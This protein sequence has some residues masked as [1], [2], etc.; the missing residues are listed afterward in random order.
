M[1]RIFFVCIL[2]LLFLMP[3]QMIESAAYTMKSRPLTPSLLN[4][5]RQG[6]YILYVRHGEAAVGEDQ[7]I[8]QL[9]DCSSQRNLTEEGRRQAVNFGESLRDLR[10]PVETPVEASPLCRTRESAELAFGEGNVQT[11]PF[12]IRIYSLGGDLSPAGQ[13]A[14]LVALSSVLERIPSVGT[15]KVIIAHSFPPGV[16]LG[17][18]PNLGTIVVKPRGQGNGYEIVSKITLEEW[19]N[20]R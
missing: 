4:S 2:A 12:W 10:I 6:G 15:N 13:Q 5:L 20:L 18:M 16:G 14:A 9:N 8:F 19:T 7:P 1:K 11:N 17:V 3:T